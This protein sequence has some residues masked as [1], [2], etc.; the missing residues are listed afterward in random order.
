MDA[1]HIRDVF[2]RALLAFQIKGYPP[3]LYIFQLNKQLFL[4]HFFH[5]CSGRQRSGMVN[6]PSLCFCDMID[7]RP[8]S[9]QTLPLHLLFASF[10]CSAIS[11]QNVHDMVQGVRPFPHK[12]YMTWFNGMSDIL[13]ASMICS[14]PFGGAGH[15]VCPCMP[16][17]VTKNYNSV[18]HKK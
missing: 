13:A 11:P 18:R 6:N 7:S 8:A 15:S 9:C 17:R 1:Q 14:K 4:I 3:S 5:L 2:R 10:V 12:M 16:H